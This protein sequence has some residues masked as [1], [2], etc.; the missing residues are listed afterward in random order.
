M[1]V[2]IKHNELNQYILILHFL[3][4]PSPS[5][6]GYGFLATCLVGPNIISQFA[7]KLT[8]NAQ[9]LIPYR[10]EFKRYTNR[11][12]KYLLSEPRSEPRSLGWTM[13]CIS[14]LCHAA[15]TIIYFIQ[16]FLSFTE[17]F[18]IVVIQLTIVIYMLQVKVE[19]Q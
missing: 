16:F 14:Q 13:D 12:R 15:H 18:Q 9:E 5:N 2:F 10:F 4:G 7:C 6:C 11:I 19:K 1:L 8:N 3:D 17:V